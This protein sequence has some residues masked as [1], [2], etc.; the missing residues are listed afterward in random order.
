M[1]FG[2]NVGL[3]GRKGGGHEEQSTFNLSCFDPI[4]EG[5]ARDNWQHGGLHPDAAAGLLVCIEAGWFL[6]V[7]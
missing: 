3:A 5:V 6:Q 4:C 2:K 1:I 7:P